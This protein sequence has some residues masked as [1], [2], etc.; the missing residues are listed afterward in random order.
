MTVVGPTASGKTALSIELAKHCNGEVIS[1]DARQVYRGLDI[2]SGKVST[3]EMDGVPHHLLDVVSPTDIYTAADFKRDGEHAIRDI[4]SRNKLPI[5]AGGTFFYVDTL[6]GRLNL[7]D[8]P[9]NPLLREK[10]EQQSVDTLFASLQN[11]DPRR[12]ETID[13]HNKVRLV[14]ALEIVEA[15][16]KVP[17]PTRSE[18]YNVC[19]IGIALSKEELHENIRARLHDRFASGMT[20]EVQ[21]LH[22]DG[23]SWERLESFGLEYR[24]IAQF[25]QKKMTEK[26]MRE[27]LE[28][29]I[30]HFAKRQL[31]WLKRDTSIHWFTKDEKPKILETVRK[32]LS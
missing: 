10:L 16:G 22:S 31:T 1:A 9:P 28:T 24:Y 14:R 25:L 17:E 27:M 2:G 5:I 7:P 18:S 26:E 4:T 8:V 6:L 23:V 29:E 20:D 15:V 32:F 11:F 13:R 19:S 30:R 3:E 12:A 21:R